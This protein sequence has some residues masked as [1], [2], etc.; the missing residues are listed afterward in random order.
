[1][2]TGPSAPA[3]LED[4]LPEGVSLNQALEWFTTHQQGQQ[5]LLGSIAFLVWDWIITFEE[6]REFIW[7]RNPWTIT[8]GLFFINRYFPIVQSVARFWSYSHE[9]DPNLS[10]LVC[11]PILDLAAYGSVL[12]VAIVEI[13]LMLRLWALYA[14]DKIFG[15]FLVVVFLVG[16]G[17]ALAIRKVEPPDGFHLVHEAPQSLTIC[18]RSSPSELFFLYAIVLVVET[19]TFSLLLWKVWKLSEVGVAPIL[20][21]MLKHGT[22]YYLVVFLALFV[23]V[24]GTVFQPLWQPMADALLVVPIASVA[25]SRLILSLRGLYTVARQQTTTLD[26]HA[27]S[28]TGVYTSCL[29]HHSS[30]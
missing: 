9:R 17:I 24:L 25:C 14:R 4:A 11:G 18:K 15:C 5:L 20:G 12:S 10:T 21:T 2:S 28:G 8:K 7:Q 19:T 30:Y 13:V 26:F 3:S 22:H 27:R 16:I 23:Q 6:E 1:M 29:P